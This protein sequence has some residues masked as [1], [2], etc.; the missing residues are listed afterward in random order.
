LKREPTGDVT[1]TGAGFSRTLVGLKEHPEVREAGI[2]QRVVAEATGVSQGTV[3]NAIE[4][5]EEGE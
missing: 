4:R 1:I 3:A 5:V 2:P